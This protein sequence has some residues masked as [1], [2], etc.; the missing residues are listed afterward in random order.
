GAGG[1]AA[2]GL[3]P[4][5][6]AVRRC[7]RRARARRGTARRAGDGSVPR[8]PDGECLELAPA[9]RDGRRGTRRI[10]VAL[11]P[12]LPA[13]ALARGGA[14][15]APRSRLGTCAAAEAPRRR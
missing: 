9:D 7:R 8:P 15:G 5:R 13:G 4:A 2:R 6:S 3:P 12:P 14:G 10:R 1:A 11:V